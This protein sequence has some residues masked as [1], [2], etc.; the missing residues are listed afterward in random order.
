MR[1][2]FFSR[3]LTRCGVE[4]TD[5]RGDGYLADRLLGWLCSIFGSME[6]SGVIST[7]NAQADLPLNTSWRLTEEL[8]SIFTSYVR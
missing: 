2:R 5:Y 3:R 4:I 8:C 6:Y 7:G 1:Q